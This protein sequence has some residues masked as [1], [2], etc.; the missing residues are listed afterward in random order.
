MAGESSNPPTASVSSADNSLDNQSTG[1]SLTYE[2]LLR[3]S[4]ISIG[5]LQKHVDLEDCTD[6]LNLN[7]TKRQ[8][9]SYAIWLYAEL[10]DCPARG[11]EL[12]RAI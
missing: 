10:R 11:E 4:G 12:A 2:E 7:P 1:D 9:T 5:T 3:M 6:T 8:R